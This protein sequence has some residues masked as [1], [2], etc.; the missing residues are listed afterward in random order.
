MAANN[1]KLLFATSNKGKL[2]EARHALEPLG[3]EVESL[4]I[5]LTE[6][7]AKQEEVSK[8]KALEARK[9]T[10]ESVLVEDTGFYIDSFNDFPGAYARSVFA[11]I[12]PQGI[13][14][15]VEGTDRKAHFV[16]I[17]SYLP[18]NVIEPLI[19]KGECHGTITNRLTNAHPQLPYDM[20]FIPDG[21]N[22]TFGE[23]S[24][25]EKAKYDHRS[26][27]FKQLAE[28]LIKSEKEQ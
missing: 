22:R 12:G 1:L 13:L 21:E 23:M 24:I 18:A 20:L 5:D 6:I 3:F 14:K 11:G 2:Q 27:A 26:K 19:F 17:I 9:H 28:Y 7:Q 4:E 10:R 25:A 15:L 8:H 16:S